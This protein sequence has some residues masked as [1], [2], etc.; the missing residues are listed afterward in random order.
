MDKKEKMEII[1]KKC[2]S[3]VFM[4]LTF[5]MLCMC[6]AFFIACGDEPTDDPSSDVTLDMTKGELLEL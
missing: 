3:L 5:A 2:M 1:V 6:A 4:L